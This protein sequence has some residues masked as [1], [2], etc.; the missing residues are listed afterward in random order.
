MSAHTPHRFFERIEQINP[1]LK[2]ALIVLFF[3]VVGILYFTPATFQ[4]RELFQADVAG[5]AGNGSDARAHNAAHP[6]DPSYWTNSLFGGMPMYQIAPSYPSTQAI[7][8]FE[9]LYTGRTPFALLGSYPW[10]LFALMLGFYIFLKSLKIP[11]LSAIAGALMWA[12][13]SYYLI[14]IAAGH[15]WKLIV[16]AY[17]PPTIAGMI[18]LY[19]GK[20]IRGTAV[21]AFFTGLQL[22]GNHLQMTY[23]FLFVMLG[24]FIYFFIEALRR[25]TWKRFA[26]ATLLSLAAGSIGIAINATNLYHTYEYSHQTMRGGSEL[27]L[28]DSQQGIAHDVNSKGLEKEYITA[29]SYGIGES[30]SLAI[31]DI[32]GGAS[33]PFGKRFQDAPQKINAIPAELRPVVMQ[34]PTYW[35]EQPF[36]SGP[37]YVGIIVI[38]LFILGCIIVRNPIKWVFIALTIFSLLLSWGKNL[39]PLTDFFI[40]YIPLYNKFR[41]VSSI[42]VIA[43]FTI[44]ALAVLALVEISRDRAIVQRH[45]KALLIAFGLP[46]LVLL[47]MAI[48]PSL[49]GHFMTQQEGTYFSKMIAQE[50]AWGSVQS[51]LTTLRKGLL[52][53]DAW[54]GIFI[55]L[56]TSI[57]LFLFYKKKISAP[58]MVAAI[59]LI[60]LGD[61]W[62]VNKRYLNDSMF[63]PHENIAAQTTLQND[64]DRQILQDKEL[65][66]RV[67]NLTVDPF[68]DASTS[69]WHHSIGGYH[70]A[71]LQ[72]YQD[73][74]DHQLRKLNPA[75]INM[76]NTKYIITNDQNKSGNIQVH[77]NP[78]AFGAAWLVDRVQIVENANEEMLALGNTDL[79]HTALVDKRFASTQLEK[80]NAP[81]DSSARIKVTAYSPNQISYD[82][83]SPQPSMVVF[84]EIYYP[85]GW[86]LTLSDGKTKEQVP[87]LRTDYVLR[88]AFLPAGKYMLTMRF[89]PTSLHTTE[90]IAYVATALLALLACAALLLPIIRKKYV[91]KK[92][93]KQ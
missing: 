45:R 76:L 47:F 20:Y 16:L 9:Q 21:L 67:L 61:L 30:L 44:P 23:Y 49:F 15:I 38:A 42:L 46:F 2:T 31:P 62:S 74:I 72:R 22:L 56:L 79:R 18:W 89:D 69:R 55:L 34:M 33:E 37:V 86:S 8:F 40:D 66:Y 24:F 53:A 14:L 85:H 51:I 64:A 88:G 13:S 71:K 73:V 83:A 25:K 84:S 32:R 92:A 65:G 28:E 7:T 90:T 82:Y 58:L 54:R 91:I 59:A 70:A 12:F 50:P 3:A 63:V 19:H 6:E 27:T 39:M 78:D 43:E 48:T 11:T 26:T 75:V 4:G 17:I 81:S 77:T 52:V 36:T 57:T 41:A 87:I 68:N 35:G 10:M 80:I 1:Y 29:W 60:T 93:Y 5:V